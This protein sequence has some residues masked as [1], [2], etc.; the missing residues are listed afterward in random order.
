MRAINALSFMLALQSLAYEVLFAWFLPSTTPLMVLNAPA[1]ASWALLP[2]LNA[3]KHYDAARWL[4]LTTALVQVGG[5][6]A[7]CGRASMVHYYFIGGIAFAFAVFPSSRIRG[8]YIYAGAVTA[9]FF[10]VELGVPTALLTLPGGLEAILRASM[11]VGL[12]FF[13]W[14][15]SFH[16]YREI[17]RADDELASA[18]ETSERLLLNILP[19]AIADRL[20][21]G[22]STIADAV[23]QATILF[24][25]LVGFTKLSE[26]VAPDDLV[27][28]LD[29]IF[30]RFDRLLDDHG[31]EKIKT[32]GDAYMAVAG[33]PH[34]CADHAER[35][36]T[37]A[38]AMQAL[39]RGE[40]GARYPGL[41]LRVGLHAGP[42]VAG[43]IGKKKF[44]YDVWGDTVNTASRM[45]SHAE[46]GQI[47]CGR[48]LYERLRS[49]FRFEERGVHDVK[50][51]GA[52]ELFFLVGGRDHVAEGDRER[53]STT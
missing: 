2:L 3:K 33:V 35:A 32:I 31:L 12:V 36:A 17:V 25:D 5:I 1:T 18:H 43:V 10:A 34:P 28:M 44:A 21:A 30:T 42:L 14:A 51:K 47:Q 9:A 40:I 24:A 11:L 20:K 22:S 45:E 15:V 26:R 37:T 6:G 7:L 29:E 52:T 53:S 13:V 4:G 27:R 23:P 19:Q 49:R 48:D 16:G 41:Q 50:G 8:L 46:P 39:M 38:L